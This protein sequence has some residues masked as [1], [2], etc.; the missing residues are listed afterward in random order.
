MAKVILG[1][2]TA[3]RPEAFAACSARSSAR[4]PPVLLHPADANPSTAASTAA[5]NARAP[6]PTLAT[7]TQPFSKTS[8]FGGVRA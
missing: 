3:A 6:V 7:K 1:V 4:L 5:V 8:R 2:F